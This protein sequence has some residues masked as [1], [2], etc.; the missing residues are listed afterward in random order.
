MP[1]CPPSLLRVLLAISLLIL[2]VAADEPSARLLQVYCNPGHGHDYQ[3]PYCF[4]CKPGFFMPVGTSDFLRCLPCAP[5]THTNLTAAISCTPCAPNSVSASGQADCTSSCPPGTESDPGGN[6]FSCFPC[7]R[8][9]FQSGANAQCAVCPIGTHAPTNSTAV[10]SLCPAGFV[11]PV[12]GQDPVPCPRGSFK[13]FFGVGEC[14]PCLTNSYAPTAG[15]AACIMCPDGYVTDRSNS[16]SPSDCRRSECRRGWSRPPGS[17]ACVECP[18]GLVSADG[19]T[20]CDSCL[21]GQSSSPGLPPQNSSVAVSANGTVCAPCRRGFHL[22][23]YSTACLACPLGLVSVD[24]ATTCGLC[25]EGHVLVSSTTPGLPQQPPSSAVGPNGTFCA[26]CPADTVPSSRGLATLGASIDA[27]CQP[28]PANRFSALGSSRCGSSCGTGHIVEADGTCTACPAGKRQLG[29]S[30][31]RCDAGFISSQAGSTA[32]FPC[33]DVGQSLVSSSDRSR[34][35]SSCLDTD[36]PKNSTTLRACEPCSPGFWCTGGVATQCLEFDKC[37]GGNVCEP[38]RSGLG[39]VTCAARHFRSGDDCSPC[40]AVPWRLLAAGIVFLLVLLAGPAVFSCCLSSSAKAV[41]TSI[42]RGKSLHTLRLL[43]Q[44]LMMLSGVSEASRARWPDPFSIYFFFPVLAG[45]R[46]DAAD[47][48][49]ISGMSFAFT[50]GVAVSVPILAVLLSLAVLVW[51]A[52]D[53][54]RK[55]NGAQDIV[56][57]A[58]AVIAV[59]TPFL[60]AYGTRPFVCSQGLEGVFLVAEPSLL[61]ASPAVS[62]LQV[63]GAFV[64]VL[65]FLTCGMSLR[66]RWTELHED[67]GDSGIDCVRTLE[68]VDFV[69]SVFVSVI[70]E[71]TTALTAKNSPVGLSILF[72]LVALSAGVASVL[73]RRRRLLTSADPA[74]SY[75]RSFFITR[76]SAGLCD[77]MVIGVGLYLQAVRR[78]NVSGVV[79][80]DLPDYHLLTLG[81]MLLLAALP[82]SISIVFMFGAAVREAVT[83]RPFDWER[84]HR[85]HKIM[86]LAFGLG[87]FFFACIAFGTSPNEVIPSDAKIG[88]GILAALVAAFALR[89]RCAIAG[90]GD[91]LRLPPP[92]P[93]EGEQVNE[94]REVSRPPARGFSSF[95]REAAASVGRA[96]P[97]ELNTGSP[98]SDSSALRVVRN[99]LA[100]S[101]AV[102]RERA[103]RARKTDEAAVRGKLDRRNLDAKEPGRPKQVATGGPAGEPTRV[104]KVLRAREGSEKR[105]GKERDAELAAAAAEAKADEEAE[106]K[107]AAAAARKQREKAAAAAAQLAV[108]A[109]E[110]REKAA[111]AARQVLSAR[112][113]KVKAAAAAAAAEPR[114]EE[115]SGKKGRSPSP[116]S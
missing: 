100:N 28:C 26:P 111:A 86:A 36:M 12:A 109:K 15:L 77:I 38:S 60:T 72:V 42:F 79:P 91:P 64:L 97:V 81:W 71:A 46:L 22:P 103:D 107:K 55:A 13:H 32:C 78:R 90:L 40:P 102:K 1:V 75:T 82:H 92:T 18:L 68:F 35:V 41:A 37:L 113:Q 2:I 115:G 50:W 34:C 61:C 88:G 104:S 24:G 63:A 48:A 116:P 114:D 112:E 65:A 85:R 70:S 53:S 96:R 87:S 106:A 83:R 14:S 31:V 6:P 49:C 76:V 67:A 101:A 105:R 5:G 110:H 44:R 47:L 57:V 80:V 19:A 43:G 11:C 89:N 52:A 51:T 17:T 74:L 30:C 4:P 108:S 21:A 27:A 58:Q 25:P 73:A 84:P 10:C 98:S 45:L 29:A 95:E 66:W 56:R 93:P 39:C 23:P 59:V 20:K 99:P 62:S 8:N 9:M 54:Q 69:V 33:G 3:Y 94:T 7:P 16:T